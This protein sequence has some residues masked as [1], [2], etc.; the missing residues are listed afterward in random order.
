[1]QS[2]VSEQSVELFMMQ[3]RIAALEKENHDLKMYIETFA[4]EQSFESQQT[5]W[6][7]PFKLRFRYLSKW[8]CFHD[9][10][11]SD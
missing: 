2:I 11:Q 1:M 3:R 5:K 4:L 8:C 7:K 9:T 6:S 10:S